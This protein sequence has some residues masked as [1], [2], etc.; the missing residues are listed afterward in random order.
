[1]KLNALQINFSHFL[2]LFTQ[3]IAQSVFA[4][5][6][7]DEEQYVI[8]YV[9]HEGIIKYYVPLLE[10]AYKKIGITP[11][12]SLI[13][14][15]R[16]L[17]LLNDGMIDADTAKSLETID[18]YESIVYLPTP[19]SRIEVYFICQQEIQC[20]RSILNNRE[21]SLAV[22]GANEFYKELLGNTQIS[23]VELTSFQVLFKV[24]EQQKVDAAIVVF[25]A[26]TKT[27]LKRY[28]NHFKVQEKLG[29]H[30]IN[31]KHKAIVKPL[32]KAISEVLAEDNFELPH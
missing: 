17:R 18:N 23:L 15:Q 14:D 19:I 9:E 5:A 30:L 16:A 8:S 2:L 11:T 4:K 32:E 31:K 21:L 12:F 10:Q 24:F 13:N 27:K 22:I 25:D 6:S 29:Y 20:D 7:E 26:Y 1:M 28:K 3:L